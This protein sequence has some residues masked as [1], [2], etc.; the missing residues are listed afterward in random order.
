MRGDGDIVP[1]VDG[2]VFLQAI[3]QMEFSYCSDIRWVQ[4]CMISGHI[5]KVKC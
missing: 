3:V 4:L 2:V 5:F 1:L